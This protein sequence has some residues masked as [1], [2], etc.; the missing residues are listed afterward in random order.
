MIGDYCFFGIEL[1]I[2][3]SLSFPDDFMIE[4]STD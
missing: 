2:A 3:L 4:S 1:T